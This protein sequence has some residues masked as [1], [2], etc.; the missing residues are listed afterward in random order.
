MVIKKIN[1][2]KV[3]D[4]VL[5]GKFDLRVMGSEKMGFRLHGERPDGTL[6]P[7]GQTFTKQT[8]GVRYGERKFRRKA[9]KV[10]GVKVTG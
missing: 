5:T 10:V 3:R 6:F 4:G 9:R 7:F 2:R 1:S 8:E